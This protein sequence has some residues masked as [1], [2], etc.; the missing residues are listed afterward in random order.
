[1]LM[2][3]KQFEKISTPQ[4]WIDFLLDYKII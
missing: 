1:M 2:D 3:F 4:S